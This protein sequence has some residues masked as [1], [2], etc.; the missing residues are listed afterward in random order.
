MQIRKP[1]L[2]KLKYKQIETKYKIVKKTSPEIKKE[3]SSFSFTSIK[4]KYS[5]D[6]SIVSG[7]IGKNGLTGEVAVADVKS[8]STV[9]FSFEDFIYALSSC[10]YGL[11][12]EAT[13]LNEYNNELS[14]VYK[15]IDKEIE[16]LLLNPNLDI[17]ELNRII[18]SSFMDRIEYTK[19]VIEQETEI[20]L[21]EWE[22]SHNETS[23][24]SPKGVAYK[25]MPDI[26]ER[27]YQG[28]RGLL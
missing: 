28:N 10:S 1:K 9:R 26:K 15:S 5:Y 25:F 3:L 19:E 23:F 21:L 8:D 18:A 2:G 16:W 7:S 27:D 17:A 20:E 22:G 6:R 24:I 4:N 12:S 14:S 11:F 13:L